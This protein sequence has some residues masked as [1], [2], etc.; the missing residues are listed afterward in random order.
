[1]KSSKLQTAI[2]LFAAALIFTACN[3]EGD[4]TGEDVS[5]SSEIDS[6]SYAFGY[7]NGMA[8]GQQGMDDIDMDLLVAGMNDG[9]EEKEAAFSQQ[10]MQGIIQ[11]YQMVKQQE[12]QER[13]QQ[14]GEENLQ[15]GED[16]LAENRSK[17]G[18]EETESGLQ[19][20]VLEE[21]DGES[22]TEESTVRVHYEGT[23]IDGEVFDS[24]YERNDPVEFPL[25]QVIAGWTEGLQL[26]NE[27]AKYKFYI[28]G[29]LGYGSNP[30][31]DSPIGPNELLIFEV[32]LLEVVDE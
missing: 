14:E 3:S 32:E 8:L 28:P 17:E 11:Q 13:Q 6:V 12:V 18:V 23:L 1:M 20:E 16:F 31:P 5:L 2:G 29:E 10:E 22:P 27:G 25:N 4:L 30:R 15:A 21:G 26:M 24:S 7:Q 19:Y 9:I